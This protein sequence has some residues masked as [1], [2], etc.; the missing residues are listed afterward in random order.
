MSVARI[1]VKLQLMTSQKATNLQIMHPA[2]TVATS[3]TPLLSIPELIY[4]C[5]L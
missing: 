1:T 3:L 5:K 2:P 4:T